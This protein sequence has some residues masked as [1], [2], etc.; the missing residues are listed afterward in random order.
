MFMLNN[1]G[2]QATASQPDTCKTTTAAG[3]VPLPYPNIA[4]SS[5]ADPGGLVNEVLVAA[6]PA[7]NQMSKVTQSSGDEAGDQGG[8]I[9]GVNVGEMAFSSGSTKV[10]VGGK[11]AVMV[12]SQT[13]QNG[14]PSNTIGVFNLGSQETVEVMQ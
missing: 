11:P 13:L 6:M 10:M 14:T 3:P 7:M 12:S 5:M 2:A 4:D 1:G 8:L 9:S